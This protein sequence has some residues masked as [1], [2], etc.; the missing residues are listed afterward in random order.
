[1]NIEFIQEEGIEVHGFL[2][3]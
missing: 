3:S 2:D 1:V